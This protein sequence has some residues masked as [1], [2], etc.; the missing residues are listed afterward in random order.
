MQVLKICRII[1]VIA[2]CNSYNQQLKKCSDFGISEIY[3]T[4]RL[5]NKVTINMLMK[6]G[7][8]KGKTVIYFNQESIQCKLLFPKERN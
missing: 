4:V 7:F 1:T 3:A 6:L 8:K 5:D 2:S